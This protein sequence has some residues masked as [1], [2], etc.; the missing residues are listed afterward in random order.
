MH[1]TNCPIIVAFSGGKDSVAMVL[2]LLSLGIDRDRI[3]LHHHLVDGKNETPIWDWPCTESYCTAFAKAFGLKLF[4]SYREGGITREIYRQN[5]GL[6][7][8][9]FQSRMGGRFHKLESNKGSSTRMR[10]P[11]VS[12]DLMTRWC[13]AVVKI[14]VLKRVISTAYPTGDLLVCTGERWEESPARSKYVQEQ[15][16]ATNSRRRPT[17]HFRPIID[18][19]ESH[20][21]DI[22]EKNLVQ[23]HPCYELGWG[24][25]S[26]MTCIFGSANIWASIE[27]LSPSR[28]VKIAGIEEDLGFTL[29]KGKSIYQKAKEGKS[30][31]PWH[32]TSRWQGEA[33]S[34]FISPIIIKNWELPAGAF[35]GESCGSL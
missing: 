25:C 13:S 28:I 22:I 23:P 10:F 5:E 19:E 26:C 17:V 32:A 11:A 8:V 18:W 33:M 29:Y 27:Q 35:K 7:P 15:V 2:Y 6:Q 21:W 16:H 12:A 14:D 20:V 1:E 4:F 24:R 34:E 30:I 3:H 31:M 9:Y